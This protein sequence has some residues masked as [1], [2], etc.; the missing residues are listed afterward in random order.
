M[1]ALSGC[2][3]VLAQQ[4]VGE[5]QTEIVNIDHA[6][7]LLMLRQGEAQRLIGNVELSQDSIFMYCDSAELMNEV[8]L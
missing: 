6:D 1:L 7:Q 4:A 5:P 2:R 3:M 8:Q